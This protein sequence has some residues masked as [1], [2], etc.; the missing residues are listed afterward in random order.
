MSSFSPVTS[1]LTRTFYCA[2]RS[3]RFS[4]RTYAEQSDT[5]RRAIIGQAVCIEVAVAFTLIAYIGWVCFRGWFF[6]EPIIT[7]DHM[8]MLSVLILTAAL[9]ARLFWI[10]WSTIDSWLHY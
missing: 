6:E 7:S 2:H 1:K 9:G 5:S 8:I 3:N 10:A 4:H